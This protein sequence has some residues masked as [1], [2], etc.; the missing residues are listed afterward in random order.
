MEYFEK[1]K[2][3]RPLRTFEGLDEKLADAALERRPRSLSSAAPD[4]EQRAHESRSD[5]PVPNREIPEWSALIKLPPHGSVNGKLFWRAADGS[6]YVD[7]DGSHPYRVAHGG[8][9]VSMNPE[10]KLSETLFWNDAEDAF[11]DDDPT[12][13]I[14][15]A[16]REARATARARGATAAEQADEAT[17]LDRR[18]AHTRERV[19]RLK[20]SDEKRSSLL[21]EIAA[22]DSMSL[23][24]ISRRVSRVEQRQTKDLANAAEIEEYM[25]GQQATLD[26]KKAAALSGAPKG[27]PA[28]QVPDAAKAD[29]GFSKGASDS[30]RQQEVE[31]L[32]QRLAQK[33]AGGKPTDTPRAESAAER[34]ARLEK[35]ARELLKTSRRADFSIAEIHADNWRGGP[36]QGKP[37]MYRHPGMPGYLFTQEQVDWVEK[38]ERGE[39]KPQDRPRASETFTERKKRRAEKLPSWSL[40]KQHRGLAPKT[41][42]VLIH[43]P[44]DGKYF[45][46]LLRSL[47]PEL[48]ESLE[49]KAAV[50]EAPSPEEYAFSNYARYEYTRRKGA[51]ESLQSSMNVDTLEFVA[52]DDPALQGLLGMRGPERTLDIL[53]VQALH[54]G[55]NNFEDFERMQADWDRLEGLRRGRK[56]LS[57]EKKL[58]SFL[59]KR[60]IDMHEYDE[61]YGV[62]ATRAE[63]TKTIDDV[64][65]QFRGEMGLVGRAFDAI[66]FHQMSRYD[67]RR[68]VKRASRI[69]KK[70]RAEPVAAVGE[71]R[72]SLQTAL[73][74]TLI[75][76][77]YVST[78]I[79]QEA[80]QR[81][82]LMP[83]GEEGA[84]SIAEVQQTQTRTTADW[85][86]TLTQHT[87]TYKKGG[88]SWK[89]LTSNERIDSLAPL[90]ERYN[91]ERRHG[92]GTFFSGILRAIMDAFFAR[93]ERELV[94]QPA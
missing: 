3:K 58:H 25:A 52:Q 65:K 43:D 1:G 33:N 82:N 83:A 31:D 9:Y 56:Y 44:H 80:I 19:E 18:R 59:D 38:R 66:T 16:T 40:E 5:E 67:A 41:F 45:P 47:S 84:R 74:Y 60:G 70:L 2:R 86:R 20:V 53:R 15:D 55:M 90:K 51:I 64:Q 6:V 75:D 29:G 7:S 68:T 63:R 35:F 10:T 4:E 89:D 93:K 13:E 61:L 73:R 48:A 77:P 42:E 76:N 12:P 54:L 72:K 17:Q 27:Q 71:Q 14:R 34:A 26:Q 22:A 57:L 49:R 87:Q 11:T 28:E 39:E 92:G 69:N 79:Y 78:Q 62:T 37:N 85:E 50:H 8:K 36:D 81:T 24:R 21:A 88:R 91:D 30:Q 94:G 23:R 32:I 46:M